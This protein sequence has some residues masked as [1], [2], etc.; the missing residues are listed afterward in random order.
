MANLST[1]RRSARRSFGSS[2][3]IGI[4]GEVPSAGAVFGQS[5]II[6]ASSFRFQAASLFR[7]CGIPGWT[8]IPHI[9]GFGMPWSQ[10]TIA[11]NTDP[12]SASC[13]AGGKGFVACAVTGATMRGPLYRARNGFSAPVAR[14]CT[15]W[16]GVELPGRAGDRERSSF[17][18]S[19]M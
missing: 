15:V 14:G 1:A 10:T 4:H 8:P 19:R 16:T 18:Y 13:P 9:A 17:P 11:D 2:A 5:I 6:R 12:S 7:R 3:N